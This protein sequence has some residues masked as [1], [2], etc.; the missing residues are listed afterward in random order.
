[1][2]CVLLLVTERGSQG[3]AVET[4]EVSLNDELV[5]YL[6]DRLTEVDRILADRRTTMEQL[7]RFVVER[8]E[9]GQPALLTFICTHNSRRSHMAQLWA[10]TAAHYFGVD[11]VETYSGGTEATAFNP[12]A[13]AALQR[14]GFLI[15]GQGEGG[16]PIYRVRWAESSAPM[17]C[18][19]KVYDR[20]PNPA[21]GFC[22]VM[23]CSAADSACPVVSG[24][25]ARIAIPFDDPK[26]FDGTDQETVKYDERCRQIAREM[27]YAFSRIGLRI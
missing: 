11:R 19:S 5:S 2:S 3:D 6:G 24:A 22:A 12:R 7:A 26:N 9:A 10:Q 14:A 20:A 1:V 21:E 16:N 4:R 13:V 27:L 17:E 18:F 15:D 25:G 8:V 23:T